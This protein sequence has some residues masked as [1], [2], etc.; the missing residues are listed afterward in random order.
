[1]GAP[2]AAAQ[3][4][5]APDPAASPADLAALREAIGL[6]AAARAAEDPVRRARLID[7]H[8]AL[9]SFAA[10]AP[11]ANFD[12][13][14]LPFEIGSLLVAAAPASEPAHG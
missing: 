1:M 10:E 4:S 5:A 8:A 7:A 3:L 9:V 11:T 13:A 6:A 12:S 2:R 14:M